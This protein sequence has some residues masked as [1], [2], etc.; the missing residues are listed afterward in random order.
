MGEA[1]EKKRKSQMSDE[2]RVR[3][4]QRKLYR[5][6]KQEESYKFYILY[7]KIMLPYVLRESYKRC[8][9][10]FCNPEIPNIANKIPQP[11]GGEFCFYR[12]REFF[13]R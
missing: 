7:D 4:F 12:I 3:D 2:E 9:R 10:V 8:K 5:K 6:A 1:L 11:L 13:T